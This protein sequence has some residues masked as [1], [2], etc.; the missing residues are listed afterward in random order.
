MYPLPDKS[1]SLSAIAKEWSRCDPRF[2][3]SEILTRLFRALWQGEFHKA[4]TSG[5]AVSDRETTLWTLHIVGGLTFLS[6]P[7]PDP[8]KELPEEKDWPDKFP[9]S[10]V[11]TLPRIRREWTTEL[12][13]NAYQE[14]VTAT[15]DKYLEVGTAIVGAIELSRVAFGSWCDSI[16]EPRPAFWF[17]DRP[18]RGE[19]KRSP[20]RPTYENEIQEAFRELLGEGQIA[21]SPPRKQNFPNIRG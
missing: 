7:E 10:V 14:M 16:H 21:L 19:S 8:K 18:K 15:A 1:L 2:S 4:A 9:E 12:L 5:D 20:G 6:D 17:S 3:E 13:D 11:N